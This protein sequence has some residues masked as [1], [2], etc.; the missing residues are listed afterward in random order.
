VKLRFEQIVPVPRAALVDRID[1]AL[2]WRLGGPLAERLIAAPHLARF[3][4]FRQAAYRRLVASGA[5]G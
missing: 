5:L 3:F 4:A 2:P 1:F